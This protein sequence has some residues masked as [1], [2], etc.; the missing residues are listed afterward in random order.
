MASSKDSPD[1]FERVAPET[2]AEG[3]V[4]EVE[5]SLPGLVQREDDLPLRQDSML[6]AEDSDTD[7][8]DDEGP[9]DEPPGSVDTDVAD[10]HDGVG[11]L[12]FGESKCRV[13]LS[14]KSSGKAVICGYLSSVCSR[15]T[16]RAKREELESRA[17]AGHYIG[18]YNASK[19][20]VD[21]LR[22]TYISYEAKQLLRD[23]NLEQMR[24]HIASSA[25]KQESELRYR[26]KTPTQLTFN[27]D[28]PPDSASARRDSMSDWGD[29]FPKTRQ[30]PLPSKTSLMQHDTPPSGVLSEISALTDLL[31]TRLD[32]MADKQAES[33]QQLVNILMDAMK[34]NR[35]AAVAPGSP[36]PPAK[37]YYAV[38]VGRQL[39]IFTRW[40]DVTASIHGFAGAKMKR[41][42]AKPA[43]QVWYD[44]QLALL[45]S[46]S[47]QEYDSDATYIEPT[48]EK[49][50]KPGRPAGLSTAAL[51][52]TPP[53]LRDI[54][55]ARMSGP[56][57]SAGKPGELF[58]TAIKVE[59]RVLEL[60]CP[61]GML[62]EV[63]EKIIETCPDVLSLPGKTSAGVGGGDPSFAWDQFAGAISDLADIGSTK[64]GHSVRDTQWQVATR[65]SLDRGKLG[66]DD[67]VGYT[68]ELTSQR[69]NVLGNMQTAMHEILFHEGWTQEDAEI[70]C[71][72][73][74]AMRLISLTFDD[75]YALLL[76][77]I[78]K[79]YKHPEQWDHVGKQHLA[80]HA[81]NLRLIRK[82]ALRRS[83][84]IFQNYIY[85]R[86]ARSSGYQSTKLLAK[87]TEELQ[88]A[89]F[90]EAV[91]SEAG[92][93]KTEW[94][95]SHCHGEHHAGG[96][97]HC[98]LASF[99]TKEARKM[100]K[101]VS[102]RLKT[103]EA[104]AVAKVIA[105]AANK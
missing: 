2:V 4:L 22:D 78:G 16:H 65:N 63:R 72:Q 91:P 84:L 96:H 67:L 5:D 17:P 97:E 104:D 24:T 50:E 85:L 86:D 25:Q 12:V 74:G 99:K 52:P 48:G 27:L 15:P 59:P 47:D 7:P 1:S 44:A 3:D 29:A 6:E 102:R 79:S 42:R 18:I 92:K 73:G 62:P 66:L 90:T 93:I 103:G 100:A 51:P 60:L 101:E 64:R 54:V 105:E 45:K 98:D 31:G 55:G 38:V 46:D 75:F 69:T 26:P 87:L 41:F 82:Y 83:Q 21:G 33:N 88:E 35:G 77:I 37:K 14:Q 94:A 40:K 19:T 23:A 56:D 13:T 36:V 57:M 61:K 76:H 20:V 34:V 81:K 68:E 58:G 49:P 28:D 8:S 39:G 89:V 95:C 30:A 9:P 53:V 71:E 80:F 11:E 10:I 43:A 70:Y 32:S